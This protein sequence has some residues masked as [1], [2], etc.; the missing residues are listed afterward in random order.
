MSGA[1]GFPPYLFRPLITGSI[2][3]PSAFMSFSAELLS[4][5]FS[6]MC[7]VGDV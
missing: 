1:P 5:G 4:P 7:P 6:K 3:S 2:N